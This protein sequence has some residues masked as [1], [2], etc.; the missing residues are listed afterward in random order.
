VDTITATSDTG[1]K[2]MTGAWK[3]VLRLEENKIGRDFVCGDLH[4]CFDDLEAGLEE[5]HFDK[6][7]DRLLCVGDLIDRGPRSER[8]TCYLHYP[9]FF[10]V[11]GNHEHMFLMGQVDIPERENYLEGHI[12]NGGGWAYRM[13]RKRVEALRAAID[14]LP[15]LIR[16]GAVIL[17]HAALPAVGSLEAIE[18]SPFDYLDTVLWHRGAYPAVRIPGINRVYVGHTITPYL[19]ERGKILNIDTGAFLKY[20]GREGK[21]TIKKIEEEGDGENT[22]HK[23]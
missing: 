15:L 12:R 5:N 11:L 10:T 16:V 4:G 13:G 21:L 19:H 20:Y 1:G 17:A 6:K 22:K 23:T 14:E 9:W 3:P 2:D 7:K 18:E 8:A